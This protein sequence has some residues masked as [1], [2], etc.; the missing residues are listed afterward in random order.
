V[1]LGLL[2]AHSKKLFSQIYSLLSRDC[3]VM[4]KNVPGIGLSFGFG[5]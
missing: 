5:F 2:S 1:L 4:K 3:L